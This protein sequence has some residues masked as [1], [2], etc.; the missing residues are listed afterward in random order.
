MPVVSG[1]KKNSIFKH[2]LWILF[3]ILI[4]QKSDKRIEKVS[5]YV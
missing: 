4:F 5:S 3:I 1:K 2:L